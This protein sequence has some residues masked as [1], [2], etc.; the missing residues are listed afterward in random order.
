MNAVK[1][2]A[3]AKINLYLD[4]I[5]KREDGFHDIRTVMHSVSLFDELT[6]AR[7]GGNKSS[8]RLELD[9][10]RRLPADSR[11]L[12]Y[13]AAELFLKNAGIREDVLIRLDKH[14]PVAAGLAGGSSDAAATLRAL[15]KLYGKCFTE[16]ALIGMAAQLGSDVPYCLIGGTA[17]C[18]GRGERMT[19]VYSSVTLHTVIAVD[20]E[21]VSTPWAY[22]ALDERFADFDGSVPRGEGDYFAS[23][24]TFLDGGEF[25]PDGLYNVFESV[26]LDACPGALEIK[27]RLSDLGAMTALMS[28]SGPSVFGIFADAESALA[29]RDA[30]IVEGKRAYY[31]TTV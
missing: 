10:N 5:G 16:R 6:V 13:A 28:G 3:Y 20:N 29:A 26:V 11:N 12:A 25:P 2:K 30:L 17:L 7:L 18:E 23:L 1:E 22:S 15:N 14:I 24:G 9:G 31:A 8:I 27:K 19:R 21:H 4:C